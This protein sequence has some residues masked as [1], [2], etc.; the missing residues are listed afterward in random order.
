[1]IEG[2]PTPKNKIKRVWFNTI[3]KTTM[4]EW[5]DGTKTTVRC[6]PKDVY[7]KEKGLAMCFVK[8]LY[9]NRGCFN[10]ELRKYLE[11]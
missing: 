5:Y 6:H 11:D 9:N 3:K 10:N 7:D 4:V 8:R 2:A 1:M